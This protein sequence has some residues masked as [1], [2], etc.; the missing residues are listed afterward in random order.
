[1]RDSCHLLRLIDFAPIPR[2]KYVRFLLAGWLQLCYSKSVHKAFRICRSARTLR[3]RPRIQR[4]N[5]SV[6]PFPKTEF[7]KN[8][9][10]KV[11]ELVRLNVVF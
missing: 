6:F 2:T 5:D 10:Q 3:G 9:S 4:E 11:K 1:M 8:K 7:F